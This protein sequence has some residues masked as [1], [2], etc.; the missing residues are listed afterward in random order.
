MSRIFRLPLFSF[1][2]IG[3]L[4]IARGASAEEASKVGQTVYL[5]AHEPEGYDPKVPFAAPLLDREVVR[6]AF[7]LAVRDELGLSTRDVILREDFPE[8]PDEQSAPFECFCQVLLQNNK[9]VVEYRLSR[10]DAKDNVVWRWI[11]TENRDT[12]ESLRTL[13]EKAEGFSRGGLKD[14]LTRAGWRGSVPAARPSADV[15][16]AALDLLWTWNEISVFAGLRRVH[17]EIRRNGESPEL[18]AALAVGYANLGSLTEYYYS[19]SCKAY[20]AR[21]LLYAERLMRKT[22]ESPWALWH[23][24]YVRMLLGL[25]NFAA[26]DVTAARK[27]QGVASPPSPLPFWTDVLEAFG[28]GDLPQML[29]IAKSPP[30]RRLARYLNLQAVQFGKLDDLTIK[31]AHD[32]LADCPD[33]PRVYDGLARSNGLAAMYEA[34]ARSALGET[35]AHLRKRLL[36]VS[37]LPDAI[38]KR[39]WQGGSAGDISEEIEFRKALIADLKHAGASELDRDEPS[40]SALGHL[41]EEIDFAQSVQQVEFTRN[42][43]GLPAG[44]RI[45]NFRSLCAAHPYAAYLNAFTLNKREMEP[46]AATLVQNLQLFAVTFKEKALLQWLYGMS[47]TARLHGWYQAVTLHADIIFADEMRGINAG[48]A[49]E[50]DARKYNRDYMKKTWNTSNKLPLSV[51]MRISRDWGHARMETDVDERDYATDPLV[52]NALADRYF[53][54]KKYD[55]AER[56]AKRQVEAAPGFAGYQLLAKVYQAKNDRIRWKQTLDKA[57]ELPPAGLEHARIRNDI[58]IDLLEH[59]EFRDAVVYADA[60]A[61]SYSEWSLLTDARCHEMLGEWK[62]SEELV[63]AVSQRYDS[64]IFAWMYWCHRTGRGDV[65]AADEFAQK[66]IEAW[67]TT[68]FAGQYRQIGLYNLMTGET[69]KALA[70][71]QR[72]YADR[73]EPY[74]GVQSALIADALGKSAD[75]DALLAQITETKLPRNFVEGRGAEYYQQ[76]AAKLREMLPPK[77]AKQIGLPEIEKILGDSAET[78]GPSTLRYFVG[79]FLKNR[80][81]LESAKTHLIRC[82][83]SRDWNAA[84]HVLACQLLHEMKIKI[85]PAP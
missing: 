46:A 32:F 37:G 44:E 85:P 53:L 34:S 41:L 84:N 79:V 13:S 3:S 27:K 24:A 76:L 69:D 77:G 18:L 66:R 28:N 16:S 43:L 2:V 45:V 48:Y 9:Y 58:A 20:Y 57:L 36:D 80:G 22:D 50:P 63:R 25:H 61:E 49:G 14:V 11:F 51:A 19:A 68:L 5:T 54:L 4:L 64:D 42:G 62:K 39:L 55:D 30:Q 40:L 10:G 78:L 35:G 72:A 52:M 17:E 31:A 1:I 26:D 12:P 47:P 83:Q 75:R 74:A 33:C 8:K 59:S 15:P 71:F 60:A 21:G 82:A 67:G 65:R 70:L 23:R 7:L 29:K 81:D 38:A 73:H 56:C 6:Q